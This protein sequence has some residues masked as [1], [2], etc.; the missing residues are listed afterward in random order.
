M[1]S[2]VLDSMKIHLMV[3][4]RKP[5]SE[6]GG[7]NGTLLLDVTLGLVHGGGEKQ[8]EETPLSP[9]VLATT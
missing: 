8:F 5:C 1:A 7:S 6:G 3:A 4:R 2:K 9:K